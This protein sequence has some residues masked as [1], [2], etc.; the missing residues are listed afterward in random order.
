[1]PVDGSDRPEKDVLVYIIIVVKNLLQVVYEELT[2][3]CKMVYGAV[4]LCGI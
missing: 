4:L 1:M 3:N 2:V